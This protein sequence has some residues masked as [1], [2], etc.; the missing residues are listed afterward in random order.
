MISF[1]EAYKKVLENVPLME[2]VL[3]PLGDAIGYYLAEDIT[4]DID[5]PPFNKS[6]MDGYAVARDG[7]H[8]IPVNLHIQETIYAGESPLKK[9]STGLC[10]KI[11][12]GA[13]VPLGTD[14]VIMIENTC[15]IDND[16]VKILK[17]EQRR[18]NIC[19]Q[20]EDFQKGEIVLKKHK[21]IGFSEIALLA[22]VG[23]NKIK[24]F[25]KPKVGIIATGNEIIKY[26]EK[27]EKGQIRNSNG[28]ALQALL[29]QLGISKIQA[30]IVRDE[31]ELLTRTIKE[32]L[33]NDIIL[34]SGGVSMGEY[35]LIPD[36]L[37]NLGA[38]ILFHKVAVKPGKP[39]IFARSKE[40]LIFGLP[41]NPISAMT[42]FR[43]IVTPALRKM[44]G[45][46]DFANNVYKGILTEDYKKKK[47]RK[48]FLPASVIYVDGTF[49]VTPVLS[50]GSA[51]VLS[52]TKSNALFILD[53]DIEKVRK[54][55]VVEFIF[56]ESGYK[57]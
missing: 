54:N 51:D 44:M 21:C 23:K 37:R 28:P 36:I 39:L 43:L 48:N 24:V 57:E 41:G 19:K 17:S 7:L 32:N 31:E 12:T 34:I 45:N 35:D 30:R 29:L 25:K 16:T 46:K 26:Y 1:D 11:M 14:T 20:G 9:V 40:N 50:H 38:D 4:S 53:E 49:R 52:M 2:T 5:M 33:T 13:E 27:P 47:G 15:L 22:S 55:S 10:S 18:T 42:I 6:A 3:L 56:K 8:K